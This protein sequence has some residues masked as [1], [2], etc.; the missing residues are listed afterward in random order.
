MFVRPVPYSPAATP[1]RHDTAQAE[2]IPALPEGDPA[3]S[4][5]M[6]DLPPTVSYVTSD[7]LEDNTVRLNGEQLLWLDR[8]SARRPRKPRHVKPAPIPHED[9]RTTTRTR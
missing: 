9:V 5:A 6:S 7:A 4:V 2:E 8:N 3:D 1:A